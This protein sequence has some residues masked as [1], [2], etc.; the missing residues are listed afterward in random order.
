MARMDSRNGRSV[1]DGGLDPWDV[2]EGFPLLGLDDLLNQPPP[3]WVID[4]LLPE[5]LAVVFGQPSTFKSFVALDWALRVATGQPCYGRE[6]RQGH[7]VYIASEGS[8]GLGQRVRAWL[9]AHGDEDLAAD[10]R[11]FAHF[12]PRTVDLT[13]RTD[14]ERLRVTAHDL[15]EPPRLVVIDTMARAMATGDENS[16]RDVGRFIAAVDRIDAASKVIVHHAGKGSTTERGSGALRGAADMMAR[17]DRTGQA[18]RV[19]L[20]CDKAPKDAPPWPDT[21]LEAER[22]ADS[23]AMRPV[24]PFAAA[25][26]SDEDRR[27]A[28]LDHLAQHGPSSRNR[29]ERAVGG[30][31]T[32]VRA[33][34]DQLV[35]EGLLDE[36][37]GARGGRLYATSSQEAGRGRTRSDEVSP[38][39]TSSHLVPDPLF[40]GVGRDEVR[41]D[42]ATSSTTSS[43]TN[44]RRLVCASCNGPL[45]DVAGRLVCFAGCAT[46]TT[47][48]AP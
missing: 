14:A 39:G 44:D 45:T 19:T 11:E 31:A 24:Q 37:P 2:L 25:V 15:P 17:V 32:A 3:E 40:R 41:D 12:L 13:D 35:A 1:G 21:M 36:S 5:G 9:D 22:V 47:E 27:D 8:G 6:V 33:T 46:P 10:V 20:T 4:G 34:L 18:M 23:L 7:V 30:R 42:L 48:E 38:S 43:T 29:I 16:S 26:R 28:V